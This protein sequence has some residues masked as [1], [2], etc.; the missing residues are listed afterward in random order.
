M[1]E[2]TCI[3]PWIHLEVR[4]NGRYS[5]CCVYQGSFISSSPEGFWNS[6][7]M[8]ELRRAHAAGEQA[9]GCEKCWRLEKAGIES[10]REVDNRRFLAFQERI[11]QPIQEPV[12]LDLK[13]GNICNL[14]CRICNPSSS[15]SWA[16]ENLKFE[17]KNSRQ[18]KI[19]K[20]VEQ[21]YEFWGY[22]Q[23]ISH[24]IVHIDFTGGEPFLIA[25]HWKFLHDC[26]ESG[27]SKDI[28]LH[29]NTNGTIFPPNFYLWSEFKS[30]EVMV[31]IDDIGARFE[32]QRYPAL[33]SEV[34]K[35]LQSFQDLSY[36]HVTV[37]TTVN[38]LNIH[39][40][41]AI[42]NWAGHKG[43]EVFLNILRGPA[44]FS[45][46]AL[47][48]EIKEKLSREYEKIPELTP[49]VNFMEGDDLSSAWP[50]TLQELQ[51]IDQRRNQNYQSVLPEY[52]SSK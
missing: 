35:N 39:N 18:V 51:R 20:W 49:I 32:Y 42:L 25:W 27:I 16:L 36:A 10:K 43:I 31:S 41:P 11:D 5:P 29:Y 21:D 52:K 6:E 48:P 47:P 8:T 1:K 50:D 3:L 44:H 28:S 2:N 37:C 7:R 9:P 14:K 23:R 38:I 40:L 4:P 19:G 33:W 12:Y 17:G 24:Q 34:E 26:V 46:Q 45:I 13:L 30:V 22:L 15:N